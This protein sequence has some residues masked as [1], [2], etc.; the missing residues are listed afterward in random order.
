MGTS[1]FAYPAWSPAFYP[2]GT[3]GEALLPAY[4]ARLPA[5]ELSSTYY[6]SPTPEQVAAWAARV[7]PE[8]RFTVKLQRERSLSAF[9]RGAAPAIA[10]LAGPLDGFGPG[11]G[12]ALYRVSPDLARDD[13]RLAS[14]LLRWPSRIPLALELAHRSWHVDE[15]HHALRPFGAALVV[16]ETDQLPE[17][18]MTLTGDFL[19]LRLRRT[20]YGTADLDAW[21]ARL[22]P[23][24]T[25]GRDAFVFFRHD[26]DGRTPGLAMGLAERLPRFD[27]RF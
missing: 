23:F 8:F 11:I 4:A 12:A 16:T 20:A 2:P 5:V 26:E 17:P 6:R 9:V 3:R 25:D 22:E 24:L 15:V 19:Y 27:P 7:P 18:P 1:G 10:A 13:E 14:L 21:A